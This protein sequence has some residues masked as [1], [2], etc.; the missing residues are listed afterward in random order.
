K[1]AKEAGIRRC[2][3][4]RKPV[5][6]AT[7]TQRRYQWAK[8]NKGRDWNMVLFTDES[9]EAY[10]PRNMTS[11]FRSGR[12]SLMVWAG[13]SYDFKTPLFRIP[14]APSR[15]E[16]S[17]RIRAEG[18]KAQRYADLIVRGPLKA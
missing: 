14:L 12:Q 13:M 6:T 15:V 8:A 3:A 4:V 9:R 5:L 17:T 11:T 10:I 16:R 2:L 7:Y 18:L 1:V